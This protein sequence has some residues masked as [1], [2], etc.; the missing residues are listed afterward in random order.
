[1]AHCIF[2]LPFHKSASG[3]GDTDGSL[4]F[5]TS[6]SQKR[7]QL[8]G[9]WLPFFHATLH[10]SASNHRVTDG[11]LHLSN[12]LL[13]F[14]MHSSGIAN[15]VCQEL[16]Q[17]LQALYVRNCKQC[18]SLQTLRQELQAVFVRNCKQC[19]SL[20]TLRQKSRQELRQE[21][22]QEL[23]TVCFTYLGTCVNCTRFDTIGNEAV[24]HATRLWVIQA[25]LRWACQHLCNIMTALSKQH[26]AKREL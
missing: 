25:A 1:M 9:H 16:R 5:L 18:A 20:Q 8:Q 10:K 2:K 11:S 6:F 19:A 15:T 26:E 3:C 17:E 24:H 21:L 13:Q 7:K 22:C 14:F 4:Y 23:Q 12:T